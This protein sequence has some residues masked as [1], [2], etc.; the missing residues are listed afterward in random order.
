MKPRTSIL[1][2]VLAVVLVT[3]GFTVLNKRWWG[4]RINERWDVHTGPDDTTPWAVVGPDFK[5]WSL[6]ELINAW[7]KG[8]TSWYPKG[9]TPDLDTSTEF[10]VT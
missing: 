1:L 5:K 7:A 8:D 10:D 2:A 6:A 4:H 9:Q 3:A